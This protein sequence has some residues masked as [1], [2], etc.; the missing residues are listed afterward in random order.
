MPESTTLPNLGNPNNRLKSLKVN[1]S[2]VTNF[3]SDTLNY[4]VN[5]P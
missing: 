3:N 5:I 2:L 4:T 1:G